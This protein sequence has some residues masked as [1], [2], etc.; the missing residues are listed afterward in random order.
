MLKYCISPTSTLAKLPPEE[1]K[2]W[3]IL[4]VV[5]FL[6]LMVFSVPWYPAIPK[7]GLDASWILVLHHAFDQGLLF[8]KDLVWHYGPLGFLFGGNY[9][10]EN[11][12]IMVALYSAFCMVFFAGLWRVITEK[13]HTEVALVIPVIFIAISY[14]AFFL[15]FGQLLFCYYF[16]VRKSL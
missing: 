5:S 8:G 2:H 16:F 3:L 12:G 4:G 9:Y 1:K 6:A 13:A 7:F 15:A 11:Y 14:D 10:P